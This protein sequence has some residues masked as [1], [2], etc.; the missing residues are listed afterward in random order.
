VCIDQVCNDGAP[1]LNLSTYSGLW[2]RLEQ[3]RVTEF[4]RDVRNA[5]LVAEVALTVG[6]MGAGVVLESGGLAATKGI[7]AAE[8]ATEAEGVE[9]GSFSI[10]DWEGYP[11]EEGLR[12]TVPFRLVPDRPLR[13]MAVV[14]GRQV[15][16][17][18]P[19]KAPGRRVRVAQLFD[20]LP[21]RN[22]I[23]AGAVQKGGPLPRIDGTASNNGRAAR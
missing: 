20:L 16:H 11:T 18:M 22:F 3:Q 19:E 23:A 7:A 5:K 9:E 2:E 21:K 15:E 1:Q 6:T 4:N 13:S 17:R 8:T 12:P 10:I 14:R